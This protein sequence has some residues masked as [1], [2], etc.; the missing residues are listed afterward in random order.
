MKE[1]RQNGFLL[2]LVH[3]LTGLSVLF[4]ALVSL[5]IELWPESTQGYPSSSWILLPVLIFGVIG[6]RFGVK[7]SAI[8]HHGERRVWP[9]VLGGIVVVAAVVYW[10]TSPWALVW[11]ITVGM[12]ASAMLATIML[13]MFE[14]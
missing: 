9:Y 8:V 12:Y 2:Y 14:E 5:A 13:V 4:Y 7:D 11:R 1:S 6:V 10:A 3:S